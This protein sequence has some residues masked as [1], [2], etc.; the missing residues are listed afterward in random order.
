MKTTEEYAYQF[1]LELLKNC[2]T[3]KEKEAAIE[4]AWNLALKFTTF[5]T[6]IQEHNQHSGFI[7]PLPNACIP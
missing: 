4:E 6:L 2:E 5:G 3:Y 7:D 1:S